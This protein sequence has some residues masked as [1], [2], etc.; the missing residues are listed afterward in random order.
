MRVLKIST[1]VMGSALVELCQWKTGS[2]EIFVMLK[3]KNPI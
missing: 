2:V 1:W 3:G